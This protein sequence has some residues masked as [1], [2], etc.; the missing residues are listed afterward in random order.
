MLK[1]QISQFTPKIQQQQF[2]V[3]PD[4]YDRIVGFG[5]VARVVTFEGVKG[6]WGGGGEESQQDWVAINLV[7]CHT[8]DISQGGGF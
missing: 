7:T 2:F 6:T 5:G 3:F 4:V 1:S 8:F